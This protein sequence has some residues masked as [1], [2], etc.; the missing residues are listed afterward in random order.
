MVTQ[1]SFPFAAILPNLYNSKS[2]R[3]SYYSVTNPSVCNN[4]VRNPTQPAFINIIFVP[5]PQYRRKPT[6]NTEINPLISAERNS[7]IYQSLEK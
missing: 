6:I 5:T 1:N 3:N 7:E 4:V 2:T